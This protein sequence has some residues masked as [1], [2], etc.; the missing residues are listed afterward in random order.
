MRLPWKTGS[1]P[2]LDGP[3]LV[4]FTRYR[5]D[6]FG[7]LPAIALAALRM[8]RWWADLDGALGVSLYVNP[9]GRTTGALSLWRDEAA[10]QGFVRRPFHI[11]IMRRYRTRGSLHSTTWWVE[12]FD[13]RAAYEEGRRRLQRS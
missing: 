9:L 2:A 12:H 11:E 4:S 7:D 13:R 8:R 3:V 1:A 5:Y 10:L 6:S